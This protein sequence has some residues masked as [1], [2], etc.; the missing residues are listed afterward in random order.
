MPIYVPSNDP[1]P[2]PVVIPLSPGIEDLVSRTRTEIGDMPKMFTESFVATGEET[3]F[4]LPVSP[5]D[6]A[7]TR[8]FIDG[9]EVG[10]QDY[11]VEETTGKI[12]FGFI[13][14]AD[15]V[16]SSTGMHYRFFTTDE[17]VHICG[18][19]FSMHTKN[20]TDAYG[21]A[22][23]PDNI[24]HSEAY[25]ISILATVNALHVLATDA[26]YDIDIQAP[27]GLS[28]PR[29]QRYQ[30]L[31][32][33]IE[34]LTARYK[35][36]CG[37]MNIGLYGIEVFTLRRI[38]KRTNRYIPMYKPQ[39]IDDRARPERVYLPLPTY[40]GQILEEDIQEEDLTIRQGDTFSQIITTV[41]AVP[42]D[43]ILRAQ[44][45]GYPGSPVV[46]V[47]FIVTRLDEHSVSLLLAHANT[48][49][50]PRQGAWDLQMN[51]PIVGSP[52]EEYTSTTIVKGRV[53]SPREV[54]TTYGQSYIPD[55]T[56]VTT[57]DY[58]PSNVGYQQNG[59]IVQ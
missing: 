50:L 9:A 16:I 51:V 55:I 31:M 5:V 6:A 26:A 54:T 57:S 35:E 33:Q 34:I 41:T 21:R 22:L 1:D 18:D 46:S 27:D 10:D 7:T 48:V 15:A 17:L 53:V 28:I 25:V 2:T 11:A 20:R 49:Y 23:T 24:D 56:G 40:G 4:Q 47:E 45:R 30:H 13:P 38:S 32:V 36:L 12:L 39:E 58:P 59:G 52:V 44:V 37:M 3:V 29:A 8:V 19:A 43:A 42:E 14:P